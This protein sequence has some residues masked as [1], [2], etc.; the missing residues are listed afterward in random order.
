VRF[1]VTR[2]NFKR[3]DPNGDGT[4]ALGCKKSN[5]P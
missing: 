1:G 3:G 5:C 2:P 4:D